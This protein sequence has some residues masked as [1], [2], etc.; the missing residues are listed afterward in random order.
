MNSTIYVALQVRGDSV[1][2][3]HVSELAYMEDAEN[4]LITCL[5]ALVP[6]GRIT[7][8][9]TANGVGNYFY[10]FFTTASERGFKSFFFP[11]TMANEYQLPPEGLLFSG[12]ER[13]YQTKHALTDPQLAWYK[14]NRAL[15]RDKFAE[16]YPINAE[17][18][19]L[20]SGNNVFPVTVLNALET[21]TP[22]QTN[23]EATIWQRSRYGAIYAVGV[24]PAEGTGHDEHSVDVIDTESGEQVAHWSGKCSMP[25]LADK[26]ATL[27]NTYNKALIIPESNNHGFALIFMLAE[28]KL[29]IY[30]REKFDAG[31]T[32]RQS[33]LGWLTTARTKAMMIGALLKAIH[34]EDIHINN[35]KT[36][37]QMKTYLY[38]EDG[39]MGAAPGKFDDCVMSMALALQGFRQLPRRYQRQNPVDIEMSAAPY[40]QTSY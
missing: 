11:W 31:K 2:N 19:F 29:P 27:S 17:E 1:N 32:E 20:A 28:M 12:D 34:E 40:V 24:D 10:D 3:L 37:A 39:S 22:I 35:P 4:R 13:K 25:M 7:I 33:K 5:A 30:K 8:E 6:K 18:A 26:I 36:I 21:S 9:S 15:F 16:V 38:L 23:E 14:Q